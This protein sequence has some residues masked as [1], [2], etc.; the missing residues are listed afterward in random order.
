MGSVVKYFP[1]TTNVVQISYDYNNQYK[2]SDLISNNFYLIWG[3]DNNE[4]NTLDL[5]SLVPYFKPPTK[6]T[7]NKKKGI[8]YLI[9]GY[10]LSVPLVFYCSWAMMNK[11]YKR[12]DDIL[13][14]KKK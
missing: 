14:E 6:P 9:S 11:I 3:L 10:I 7:K 2:G 4:V 13:I 5:R 8:T 1:S 12:T